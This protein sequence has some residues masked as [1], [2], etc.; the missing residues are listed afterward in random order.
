M[1]LEQGAAERLVANSFDA[2][3]SKAD[4]VARFSTNIDAENGGQE[5]RTGT[6]NDTIIFDNLDDTKAGLSISDTVDAGEG[7]DTLIIDGDLSGLTEADTIKLSDSEWTNVSGFETLRMAGAGTNANNENV[8]YDITLTDAFISRNNDEGLL[9][10]VN[11]NSTS[12]PN[13]Y[14]DDIDEESAITIHAEGLSDTTHFSY[15]GEEESRDEDGNIIGNATNDR[16]IV[17]DANVNGQNII[18]GGYIENIETQ[19][20]DNKEINVYLG[21]GDVLEIRNKAVVTIGDLD[22]VSNI[23]TIEFSNDQAVTQDSTLE[24]NDTVVDRLVYTNHNSVARSVNQ[25]ENP[26]PERLYKCGR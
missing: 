10:I 12:F 17:S 22:N 23:G 9:H 2:S 1:I 25:D 15:N 8:K 3:E 18:D 21:N 19:I 26:S 7:F 16:I 6:G 4:I 11:D 20:E 14:G 5:I 24:L 13:E